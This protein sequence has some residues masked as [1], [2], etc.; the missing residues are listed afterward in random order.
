M[1]RS[2]QLMCG[3][4][5]VSTIHATWT[6]GQSLT[7]GPPR[8]V[9]SMY[10]KLSHITGQAHKALLTFGVWS[11]LHVRHPCNMD[12]GTLPHHLAA[13]PCHFGVSQV[14]PYHGASSPSRTASNFT[15]TYQVVASLLIQPTLIKTFGS[16]YASF[17]S[18][19]SLEEGHA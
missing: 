12:H 11:A 6:M 4:H 18:L 7:T 10:L 19:P 9:I 3:R 14:V 15:Q 8:H 5:C 13:T 17:P 2:S 16:A 1:R